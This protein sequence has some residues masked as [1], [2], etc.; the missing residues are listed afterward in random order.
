MRLSRDANGNKTL[1]ITR[2]ECGLGF[3]VQ[4]LGN[5][6][7]THR[8]TPETFNE[9][10]AFGELSDYVKEHG[11]HAQKAALGWEI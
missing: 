1:S 6:P 5:L 8:M 9:F 7:Q 4:T 10:D 11:T 3:S 2:A